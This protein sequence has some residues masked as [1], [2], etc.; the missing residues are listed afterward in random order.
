M[1]KIISIICFA[2]ITSH[3]LA[4]S[5]TMEWQGESG[6]YPRSNNSG[7][8]NNGVVDDYNGDGTADFIMIHSEANRV[9]VISGSDRRDRQEFDPGFLLSVKPK[10]IEAFFLEGIT[11]GSVSMALCN[12]EV[13]GVLQ[14]LRNDNLLLLEG[15]LLTFPKTHH[16]LEVADYDR[17]GLFELLF[18]NKKEDRA[19]IWGIN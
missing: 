6:E 1:K 14:G 12:N 15:Q 2:F 19:E 5:L 7:M 8:L 17:D 18:A 4:Q 13:I 11:N 9:Y 16:L 3:M 10:N